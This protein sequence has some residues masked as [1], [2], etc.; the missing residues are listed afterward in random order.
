[1]LVCNSPFSL[2]QHRNRAFCPSGTSGSLQVFFL[3]FGNQGGSRSSDL[4]EWFCVSISLKLD[5]TIRSRGD[6]S[7]SS[8]WFLIP[9][10]SGCKSLT[11][12]VTVAA[13]N[14]VFQASKNWPSWL[15][16]T[17]CRFWSPRL[18]GVLWQRFFADL[19][20]FFGLQSPF[21]W[22]RFLHGNLG[23][24][25]SKKMRIRTA[26][27]VFFFFIFFA[28]WRGIHWFRPE[29][30]KNNS[31]ERN[32]STEVVGPAATYAVVTVIFY[33]TGAT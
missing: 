27:F 1:M 22:V 31:D 33:S 7:T 20:T 19:L 6:R 13:K 11:R 3:R 30:E 28:T 15:I 24:W 5:S 4:F 18:G 8:G 29:A 23:T 21:F 32:L 2:M 16:C 25:V 12:D 9:F 26:L 10:E 14:A 17:A